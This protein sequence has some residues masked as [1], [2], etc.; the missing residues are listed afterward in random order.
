MLFGRLRPAPALLRL[1]QGVAFQTVFLHLLRLAASCKQ[2]CVVK[3]HV[4]NG[5]YAFV[6]LD[7]YISG[8]FHILPAKVQKII[9]VVQNRDGSAVPIGRLQLRQALQDDTDADFPGADNGADLVEIRDTPCGGG[10]KVIH[11]EPDRDAQPVPGAA[12][13]ILAERMEGLRIKQR[14][15]CVHGTVRVT[16]IQEHSGLSVGE[17]LEIDLL[18]VGEQLLRSIKGIRCQLFGN[19]ALNAG[20]GSGRALDIAEHLILDCRKA[21]GRKLADFRKQP[22]KVAGAHFPQKP[23]HTAEV[24]FF[25]W[26]VY[27]S[28]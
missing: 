23:D 10:G 25:I 5:V 12:V 3:G 26:K 27:S 7:G 13:G 19:E 18:R 9:A 2:P 6:R 4:Q 22:V 15:Q 21:V 11:D 24:V 16:D 17:V 8:R 14:Y 20:V 1:V 28:G